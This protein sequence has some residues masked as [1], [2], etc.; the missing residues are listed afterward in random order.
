MPSTVDGPLTATAAALAWLQGLSAKP[1]VVISIQAANSALSATATLAVSNEP[2]CLAS[3]DAQATTGVSFT[4]G[5][6]L[7][8]IGD[9]IN[10]TWEARQDLNWE[11]SLAYVLTYATFTDGAV[12][13]VSTQVGC[14]P[15]GANVAEAGSSKTCRPGWVPGRMARLALLC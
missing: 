6:S 12:M 4:M 1:S 13:D 2:V 7:P 10:A 8:A 14:P 5:A 9:R 11:D 3:L 15:T